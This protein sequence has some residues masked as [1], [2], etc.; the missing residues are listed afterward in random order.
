MTLKPSNDN[1]WDS[2]RRRRRLLLLLLLPAIAL[3]WIFPATSS[4]L[5]DGLLSQHSPAPSA[6]STGAIASA[7][8]VVSPT[9]STPAS[10]GLI[11]GAGLAQ[12][13]GVDFTIS[14]GGAADLKLGAATLIRLTL[15]NPNDV[16]IYVTALT[17]TVS[18]DSSPSGCQ[19]QDNIRITQSDVSAADP[20]AVPAT[21][22]VTLAS[23]PRAPQITLLNLPGVNQDLCK[24]KVFDLVYTGIAHS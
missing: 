21:G 24:G 4:G 18:P 11:V 12:I 19:T 8:T 17:A 5:L 6:V 22:V 14:G 23:A 15:A 2:E 9:L 1:R 3:I 13:S 10:P 7:P 20:I 16:P